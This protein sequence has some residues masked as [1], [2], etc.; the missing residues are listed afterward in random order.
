MNHKITTAALLLGALL[1]AGT[2]FADCPGPF[3][4]DMKR[5]NDNPRAA[6]SQGTREDA[7]FFYPGAQGR[8]RRA[9][10]AGCG[11][12]VPEAD[13]SDRQRIRVGMEPYPILLKVHR[14]AATRCLRI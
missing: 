6:E 8:V 7:L 11:P 10:P 5:S 12:R 14:S 9:H 3:V 13:E 2:V 4:R 1:S